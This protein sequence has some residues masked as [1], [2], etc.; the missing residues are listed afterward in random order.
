MNYLELMLWFTFPCNIIITVDEAA[1]K[2]R[3]TV[4]ILRGKQIL[5]GLFRIFCYIIIYHFICQ[6][7]FFT[8]QILYIFVKI[9]FR[10]RFTDRWIII[11]IRTTHGFYRRKIEPFILHLNIDRS[12]F[13]SAQKE[14]A[15]FKIQ[16]IDKIVNGKFS[17]LTALSSITARAVNSFRVRIGA[18][19]SICCLPFLTFVEESFSSISTLE[20]CVSSATFVFRALRI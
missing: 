10:N 4:H 19:S 3:F 15:H 18:N 5:F 14:V 17:V 9:L 16:D 8:A 2:N 13:Y 12:F 20:L 7:V 1:I 6:C 11:K